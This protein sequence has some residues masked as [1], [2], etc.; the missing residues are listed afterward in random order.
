MSNVTRFPGPEIA[1]ADDAADDGAF[2]RDQ[3]ETLAIALAGLKDELSDTLGDR[4]AAAAAIAKI[5]LEARLAGA[6]DVAKDDLRAALTQQFAKLKDGVN[7]ELSFAI[8]RRIADAVRA[9]R[10]E[11]DLNLG[12]VRSELMAR[13]DDK[14][15]GLMLSDVDPRLLER[16]LREL[17]GKLEERLKEIGTSVGTLSKRLDE[18]VDRDVSDLRRHVE[19]LQGRIGS[20]ARLAAQRAEG[21]VTKDWKIDLENYSLSPVTANGSIGPPISLRPMFQKFFEEIGGDAHGRT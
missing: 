11:T 10:E 12:A 20:S 13:I 2:S 21:A 1:T 6:A 8:E 15:F 7:S 17:K 5:E 18:R 16:S 14:N 19:A 4:I 9:F 3:V